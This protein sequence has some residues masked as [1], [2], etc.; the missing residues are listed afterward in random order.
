MRSVGE[1]ETIARH[2]DLLDALV[3]GARDPINRATNLAE[4]RAVI[5]PRGIRPHA[6][7][8]ADELRRLTMPTLLVWG[9]DDPVASVDVAEA[10]ARLI[11][12]AQVEVLSA[13]HVPWLGHPDRV[14]ELL[15][16]FTR[17]CGD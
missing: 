3:A 12:D 2:P 1:G 17:A 4:L 15:S 13:G 8:R 14:A 7:I 5:S 10:A 6:L 16:A 9:D 11:P